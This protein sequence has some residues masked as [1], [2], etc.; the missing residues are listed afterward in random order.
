[1]LFSKSIHSFFI[2]CK[3]LAHDSWFS[4]SSVDTS[5]STWQTCPFTW[6]PSFL[7]CLSLHHPH[8]WCHMLN[9]VYA[10]N[11]STTPGDW[12]KHESLWKNFLFLLERSTI[13]KETFSWLL[14]DFLLSTDI[15]LFFFYFYSYPFKIPCLI[16]SVTIAKPQHWVNKDIHLLSIT[17]QL[18]VLQDNYA[19]EYIWTAVNLWLTNAKCPLIN[20]D[21]QSYFKPS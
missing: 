9:T 3:L 19:L 15:V 17:L 13:P 11:Y 1:M 8:Y 16:T 7:I 14:G 21:I 10:R 6:L 4:L 20:V 5:V 2:T 12:N 18:I